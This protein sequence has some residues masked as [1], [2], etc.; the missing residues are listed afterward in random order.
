MK[1]RVVHALRDGR[2]RWVVQERS[3]W[4]PWWHD[5]RRQTHGNQFDAV[6]A[7]LD[8]GPPGIRPAFGRSDR[9]TP[10]GE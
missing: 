9:T 7:M 1:R 10:Y 8:A 3:W 5:V 4:R 2:L 6:V